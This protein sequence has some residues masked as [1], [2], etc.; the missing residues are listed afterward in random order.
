MSRR[1]S[2][3]SVQR[4][5][6]RRCRISAFTP[7]TAHLPVV[8]TKMLKIKLKPVLFAIAT[9]TSACIALDPA[10]PR[11][12]QA[13]QTGIDQC[14]DIGSF[15]RSSLG[16][17]IND[18]GLVVGKSQDNAGEQNAFIYANG[19]IRPLDTVVIPGGSEATAINDYDIVT[20]IILDLHG[21]EAA[22]VLSKG[23][24]HWLIAFS[25]RPY[26]RPPKRAIAPL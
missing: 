25:R 20:G 18:P 16:S 9:V 22:Y 5:F 17:A 4:A 23:N 21:S 7:D 12:A 15:G 14:K 19:K 2:I 24:L 10:S 26:T 8:I 11:S 6:H 3:S 13:A 1:P